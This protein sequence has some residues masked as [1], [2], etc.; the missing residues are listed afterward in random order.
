MERSKAVTK[1]GINSLTIVQ[2]YCPLESLLP[3]EVDELA[4]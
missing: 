3:N 4:S 1:K 2:A